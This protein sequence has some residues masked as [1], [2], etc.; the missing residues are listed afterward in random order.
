M[1]DNRYSVSA[2]SPDP[3]AASDARF[4]A[5]VSTIERS[6]INTFIPQFALA[7]TQPVTPWVRASNDVDIETEILE[8][9]VS[10]VPSARRSKIH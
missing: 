4:K 5:L 3:A 9:I 6:G 1:D 2:V 10:H 8:W 7:T